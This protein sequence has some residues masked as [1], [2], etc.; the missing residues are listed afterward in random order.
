MTTANK[1]LEAWERLTGY[2]PKQTGNEYRGISPLRMDADN[3][4][5]FVLTIED[6]EHGAWTDYP[7][8]ETGSL[9]D[10]AQRLN[11]PLPEVSQVGTTLRNYASVEDYAQAHGVDGSV[12][13]KAGW[14]YHESHPK[15]KRPCL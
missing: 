5:A 3:K 4:T 15:Y 6:G 12:F 8:N 11:V 2:T 9:Y 10:L 7:G 14:Q 1:V 13:E